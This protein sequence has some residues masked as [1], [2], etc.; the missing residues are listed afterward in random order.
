M[1]VRGG[2]L[3]ALADT[4]AA[5]GLAGF[6]VGVGF[7]LR[8]CRM[9][10]ATRDQLSTKASCFML[11]AL[12]F[13]NSMFNPYIQRVGIHSKDTSIIQLS[14]TALYRMCPAY[15]NYELLL[16][17]KSFVNVKKYFLAHLLNDRIES[18]AYSTHEGI[19][20][21]SPIKPAVFNHGYGLAQV[22][23][24]YLYFYATPHLLLGSIFCPYTG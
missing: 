7:A 22:C 14:L 11:H 23:H 1:M 21:P 17:L 5:H 8:K 12:V 15:H 2:V 10:L 16:M 13:N 20:K 3:F 19:N 9:C 4:Q 6:K 18:F 24:I